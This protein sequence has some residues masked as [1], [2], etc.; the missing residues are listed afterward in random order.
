M[1]KRKRKR[2]REK[3]GQRQKHWKTSVFNV[4]FG[5]LGVLGK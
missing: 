3:K 5:F 4:F 2:K 1:R